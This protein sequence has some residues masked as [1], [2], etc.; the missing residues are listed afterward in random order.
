MCIALRVQFMKTNVQ[1]H[2]FTWNFALELTVANTYFGSMLS[3]G[4]MVSSLF[5]VPV[6]EQINFCGT[7]FCTFLV[8][9]IGLSLWLEPR[10]CLPVD[11]S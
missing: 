1:N 5:N 8:S 10:N 4:T 2:V 6:F 9:F 7:V 11:Y 3:T